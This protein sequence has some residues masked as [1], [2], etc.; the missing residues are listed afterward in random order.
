LIRSA[1][2]TYSALAGEGRISPAGAVV[3]QRDVFAG[4]SFA[5]PR[6]KARRDKALSHA[7]PAA[8]EM[9]WK[10]PPFATGLGAPAKAAPNR[11]QLTAITRLDPTE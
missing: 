10:I 7:N 4:F 6:L 5:E 3:A 2:S 9:R 1:C 11:T 8:I